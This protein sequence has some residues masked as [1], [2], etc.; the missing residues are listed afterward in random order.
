MRVAKFGCKELAPMAE[1]PQELQ[2][3]SVET[4]LG[5]QSKGRRK[6]S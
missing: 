6:M 5:S 1:E 3:A 4:Q 2:R